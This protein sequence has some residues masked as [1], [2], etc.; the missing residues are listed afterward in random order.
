MHTHPQTCVHT[1]MHVSHTHTHENEKKI[2]ELVNMLLPDVSSEET[3]CIEFPDS[4][5]IKKKNLSSAFL[6]Q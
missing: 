1:Q 3:L 6:V 5:M 2:Y 4:C